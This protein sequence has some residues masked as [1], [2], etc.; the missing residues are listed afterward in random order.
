[1]LKMV[2][3]ASFSNR[4]K[5]DQNDETKYIHRKKKICQFKSNCVDRHFY[6]SSK[7]SKYNLT[8]AFGSFLKEEKN[9]FKKC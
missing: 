5:K 7:F 3:L 6:T 2:I 1:M 8:V 4:I 9:Q